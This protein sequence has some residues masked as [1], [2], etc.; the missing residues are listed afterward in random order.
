MTTAKTPSMER[1]A[2]YPNA[3]VM[4]LENLTLFRDA[5]IQPK[6]AAPAPHRV[7]SGDPKTRTWNHKTSLEA[8]TFT[9]LWEATPGAWRVT[10]TKWEF[11]R[12]LSGRGALE[13]AKGTRCE[14]GPGDAFVI[15]PGFDGVWLVTETVTKH[16]VIVNRPAAQT[17]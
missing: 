9:G 1:V 10:Y 14:I 6:L 12:I 7:V 13:D 5:D 15:E 4:K 17:T 11:C 16:Y 3:I 2:P 8:T